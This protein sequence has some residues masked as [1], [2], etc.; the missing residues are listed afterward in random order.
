[1][2]ASMMGA[3]VSK[4]GSPAAKPMISAPCSL[5]LVAKSVKA[6]VLEGLRDATLGFRVGSTALEACIVHTAFEYA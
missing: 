1:M 6:M 4:S 3:G 5:R 2:P